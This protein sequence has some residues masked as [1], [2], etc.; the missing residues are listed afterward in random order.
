MKLNKKGF[1]ITA[2]LYGLLILFVFLVGSYLLILSARKARVDKIIK[3]A[4]E[5]YNEKNGKENPVDV[6]EASGPALEVPSGYNNSNN[7][8][9]LQ[10]YGE[11]QM[12]AEEDVENDG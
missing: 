2:I 7:N 9:S 12:I 4:E 1:A 5:R 3:N 8:G 10:S 6:Y 11:D